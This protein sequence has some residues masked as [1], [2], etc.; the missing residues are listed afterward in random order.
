MAPA[1]KREPDTRALSLIF[2][3]AHVDVK[4]R[5]KVIQSQLKP[6]CV[7]LYLPELRLKTCKPTALQVDNKCEEQCESSEDGRLENRAAPYA[8]S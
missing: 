6:R 2:C 4:L 1:S 8:T 7:R 3:T 5:V